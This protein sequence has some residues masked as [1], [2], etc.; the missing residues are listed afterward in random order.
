MRHIWLAILLCLTVV[1]AGCSSTLKPP[2]LNTETGFFNKKTALS[3]DDVKVQEPFQRDKYLEQLYV[4][5][6]A[7]DEEYNTFFYEAFAAMD[8][9]GKIV[10]EEQLAAIVLERNLADKVPSISDLVGLHNLAAHI[11]PFLIVEPYAA[12]E[13]GYN[14]SARLVAIDPETGRTVLEIHNDAVNW[15]GLDKPLFYP[16]FNAFLEWCRGEPISTKKSPTREDESDF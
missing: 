6:D 5:T 9:F 16:L 14:Y 13:G 1:V 8:I 15:A 10:D 3:E 12:H 11:G 7:K 4:K 2:V